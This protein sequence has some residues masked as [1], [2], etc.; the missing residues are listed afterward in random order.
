[1]EGGTITTLIFIHLLIIFYKNKIK[2]INFLLP[3]DRGQ[4]RV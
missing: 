3:I 1:M 2:M 4:I